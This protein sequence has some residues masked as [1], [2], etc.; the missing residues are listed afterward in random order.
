MGEMI[1]DGIKTGYIVSFATLK[2]TTQ[3]IQK[4]SGSVGGKKYEEDAS[5]IVVGQQ[6][7]A[8]G[9]HHHYPQAQTQAYAQAPQNHSQNLLYFIPPPP[10]PVYNAQPYVQFPS[11]PQWRAP[12]P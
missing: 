10:Y 9:P 5:A 1:E 12:T 11:Y 6:A 7:R 4:G 3:A 8:R 2:A